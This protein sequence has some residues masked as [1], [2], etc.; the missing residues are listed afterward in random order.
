[1]QK[2]TKQKKPVELVRKPIV[3]G[4]W[5]GRDAKK[6]AL[7]FMLTFAAVTLVYLITG[8]L[9]SF[10]AFWLRAV[11]ALLIVAIV[12][13]YLY[14]SG[15]TKG[16]SDAAYGEILFSRKENGYEISPVDADRSFHRFKGFFAVLAGGL[17]FVIF[18]LVFACIT[19]KVTYTLGALPSWT[20]EMMQQEEFGA[21]LAYYHQ[22]SG[23]STLSILRIVDRAMVMPFVNIAAPFGA[24]ALLLVERLSPL[25][26]LVA[27][28]WYGVG[29]TQ[30]LN[31]RARINT[32][33]KMGDDKKKRRERKARKKRQQSKTPERLI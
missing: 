22:Q 9:M 30:G 29:Y 26:V 2:K 31:Y 21:A 12:A 15:L 1:M 23:M 6:M 4:S 20:E 10:E 25:L 33:I 5:C 19:Q 7:K 27:P 14:A 13:Y 16:Q 32:G 8:A 18:A 3:A 28:V 17:P 24:D 11:M